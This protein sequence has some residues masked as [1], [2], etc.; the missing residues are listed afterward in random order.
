MG[1]ELVQRAHNLAGEV[2]FGCGTALK[3]DP[4]AVD[5]AWGTGRSGQVLQDRHGAADGCD[6]HPFFGSAGDTRPLV[7]GAADP[8]A[9]D[10]PVGAAR[11]R[12]AAGAHRLH[13]AVTP[14][15]PGAAHDLPDPPPPLL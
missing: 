13:P 10:E 11:N 4:E 9:L 1:P 5:A 15:A 12:L 14:P 6:R 7:G 3:H 2:V 8:M